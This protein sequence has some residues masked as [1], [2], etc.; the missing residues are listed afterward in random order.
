MVDIKYS[1]IHSYQFF[2]SLIKKGEGIWPYDALAT[3]FFISFYKL[4]MTTK[5]RC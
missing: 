5:E 1:V 3:Y 4:R 2:K